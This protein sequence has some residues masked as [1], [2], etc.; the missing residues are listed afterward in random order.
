MYSSV[1]PAQDGGAGTSDRGRE[2]ESPAVGHSLV[3]NT[4]SIGS[5]SLHD[6]SSEYWDDPDTHLSSDSDVRDLS[7]H[8]KSRLKSVVVKGDQR[9]DGHGR[10]FGEAS[11]EDE[12][13]G[14]SRTSRSGSNREPGM[15]QAGRRTRATGQIF[16]VE[17][18]GSADERSHP[19]EIVNKSRSKFHS[20]RSHSSGSSMSSRGSRHRSRPKSPVRVGREDGSS[21]RRFKKSARTDKHKSRRGMHAKRSDSYVCRD[22][23]DYFHRSRR[24]STGGP[25]SSRSPTPSRDVRSKKSRVKIQEPVLGESSPEQSGR[26]GRRDEPSRGRTKSRGRA[27]RRAEGVESKGSCDSGSSHE[28]SRNRIRS[29]RKVSKSRRRHRRRSNDRDTDAGS[30][31][32]PSQRRTLPT[33]KLGTYDGSSCLETFLAKFSNCSEY[34]SWSKTDELFHLRA[35]L[36]GKAGSVLWEAKTCKTALELIALLR[37]RFGTENQTER[38]RIELKT[39]KR[40]KNESLQ[41]LYNDICR[42]MSL[43]YPGQ[44]GSL[45]DIV[46]RDAFLESL[47]DPHMRMKVLERDPEPKT[48]E[49]A[50]RIACRLEALKR[51]VDDDKFEDAKNREKNVRVVASNAQGG[52]EKTERHIKELEASLS[53][54]KQKLHDVTQLAQ[55]LQERVNV[56]EETV[57]QVQGQGSLHIGE[58]QPADLAAGQ[59]YPRGRNPHIGN[60]WG[61]RNRSGRGVC[62][63]CNNPGHNYRDCTQ[64]PPPLGDAAQTSYRRVNADKGGQTYLATKVDGVPFY[65]LL[66]S[67]AEYSTIPARFVESSKLCPSDVEL[68]AA[69]NSKIQVLGKTDVILE[70]QGKEIPTTFLVSDQICEILLGLDFLQANAVDCKFASGRVCIDGMEVPLLSR[71]KRGR[72]RRVFATERVVVPAASEAVVPIKLTHVDRTLPPADWLIEPTEIQRGVLMARTLVADDAKCR[73]VRVINANNAPVQLKGGACVG[74]AEIYTG[75]ILDQSGDKTEQ[76]DEGGETLDG[77]YDHVKPLIGSLPPSLTDGQRECAIKVIKRNADVFSKNEYDLGRTSLVEHA[78]DVGQNRPFKEPLRRHPKAYLDEIDRHVEEMLKHDIIEP[79]YGPWASNLVLVMKK[80]EIDADGQEKRPVRFCIDYRRLNSLTYKDSFP[81]P[82]IDSCLDALAGGQIYC[83]L[84]LKMSFWQSVVRESDRDKTGFVSR[85]GLWRFKVLPYGLVNSP[86]LF[87]RLMNLVLKGLTWKTCLCYVDDVILVASSFEQ[88]VERL[89]E[90]LGRFRSAN[91]KLKPSKCCLFQEKVHFLGHLVSKDG[92]Q[93][94]SEK[95]KAVQEWPVPRSVSDVRAFV[96][97]AGYYRKFQKNFS[98]IAAPLHELTRKGEKFVWD[99][100]RQHAFEQLKLMLTSAPVLSLARD[101]GGYVVDVDC[102]GTATGGALQQYQDGELRVI[103]YSSR[104]LTK[105]ERVYC[106]TRRELLAIVHA[107]KQWKTYLLGQTGVVLRTDH[108][109]LTFLRKTPEPN[110]QQARWLN[111]IEMFDLRVEHRRGSSH[112][113]ADAL[114]RRPCEFDTPCRQCRGAK[115]QTGLPEWKETEEANLKTVTTRAK[116]KKQNLD[117]RKRKQDE[118]ETETSQL[119]PTDDAERASVGEGPHPSPHGPAAGAA[120]A[121]IAAGDAVTSPGWSTAELAAAQAADL[122][123]A[124]IQDWLRTGTGRPDRKTV[125]PCSG[126]TRAYWSQ[127]D[128]LELRDDVVYRKFIGNAGLVDYYQLLVPCSLRPQFMKMVHERAA[129]HLGIEKTQSQIQRRGYWVGWR[130]DVKLFS[131]NCVPCNVYH[132]GAVPKQ[133]NLQEMRVGEPFQRIHV[134]ITGV[135]PRSDNGMIYI[136]TI[137]CAF[138]KFAIAIPLPNKSA[139]IVTQALMEHV[140]LKYGTPLSIHSDMGKRVHEFCTTTIM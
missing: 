81:L 118:T 54:C 20:R 27:R 50:L 35:S 72:V 19:G 28:D 47:A 126:T 15:S 134:D 33:L 107:L 11:D 76:M 135:H 120:A 23:D 96:A 108:A 119:T 39:R 91:L 25:V 66:D 90:V 82:R 97:L 138:S 125:A 31:D 130:K 87:Q 100:R 58:T 60:R 139:T 98:A 24:R 52:T 74:K 114:S 129:G 57:R 89:E 53:E 13:A 116:N 80:P 38:Y 93:A 9:Q 8:R 55:R 12:G 65:C 111:F 34:Y 105:T 26:S 86:S 69:N 110:G 2:E 102:S 29:K 16:E 59:Y 46:S 99:E 43:S 78:I 103:A 7:D 44:T 75:R 45:C 37:N 123:I 101:E 122:D 49:E 132:R 79:G 94:D 3:E 51:N 62:W 36:E 131:Q 67:G 112:S 92:I 22:G 68:F 71:P 104:L 5:G 106:T 109:A 14:P 77:G 113:N 56:S 18:V 95:I 127:W 128:S 115:N 136:L 85:K 48:I 140:I 64:P 10:H 30:S 6:S 61:I 83:T 63:R 40:K 73:A 124:P 4:G 121:E 17:P 88:M 42:L 32:A 41:S 70:I 137:L 21:A 84:D 1:G 117:G 133:G